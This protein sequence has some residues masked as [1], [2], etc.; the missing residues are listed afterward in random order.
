MIQLSNRLRFILPATLCLSG[1]LPAAAAAQE[2]KVAS[3]A[4]SLLALDK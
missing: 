4:P 3:Q 2:I 1:L